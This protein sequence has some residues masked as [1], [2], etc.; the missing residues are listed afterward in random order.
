MFPGMSHPPATGL[1]N[2][3]SMREIIDSIGL[4]SNLV[5]CLDP[6]D[7]FSYSTAN[8]Q[9]WIDRSPT[10]THFVLGE[11]TSVEAV[12]ATFNGTPG[13]DSSN[14]YWTLDTNKHFKVASGSNPTWV[15][16]LGAMGQSFSMVTWLNIANMTAGAAVIFATDVNG[17]DGNGVVSYVS[18]NSTSAGRISFAVTHGSNTIGFGAASPTSTGGRWNMYGFTL[19]LVSGGN[20]PYL[21]YCNGSVGSNSFPTTAFTGGNPPNNVI[22]IGYEN[23][24]GSGWAT[25]DKFGA[26][27]IWQGA[28]FTQSNYDAIFAATRGKYGV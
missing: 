12:D 22:T 3:S 6:G 1:T 7:G 23:P 27:L 14:E 21:S 28:A 4:N 8:S 20:S 15:N 9:Y 11:T 25:T 26:L 18:S 16:N 2:L 24:N 10:A 5:L 13:N 19:T 17:G